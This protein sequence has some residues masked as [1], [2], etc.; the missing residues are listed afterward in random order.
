MI[1]MTKHNNMKNHS[2]GS[3]VIFISVFPMIAVSIGIIVYSVY[4]ALWQAVFIAACAMQALA[5]LMA[6]RVL[7]AHIYI[8]APLIALNILYYLSPAIHGG[9]I[10]TNALLLSMM[11]LFFTYYQMYGAN[12][13]ENRKF[14]QLTILIS[15]V[16]IILSTFGFNQKNFDY[17]AAYYASLL[18]LL[19]LMREKNN[20]ILIVS[21]V[22][23][24]VLISV[25]SNFR[26]MIVIEMFMVTAYFIIS[27]NKP[28][29]VVAILS[30]I[31]FLAVLLQAFYIYINIKRSPYLQSINQVMVDWTGRQITSGR[32][33]LW[34]GIVD[35]ISSQPIFGLGGN[36]RPEDFMHTSFSA[37]NYYLQ[38]T[39]QVGLIGLTL[40]II[41]LFVIWNR[42]NS[43]GWKDTRVTLGA[44]I[45]LSFLLH[46]FSEVLMFQNAQIVALNAWILIGITCGISLK[47][48]H[49]VPS[50]R[51]L[52]IDE[53]R[54]R[55]NST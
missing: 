7:Y 11:L 24:T 2:P 39:L 37:H 18:I 55:G 32:E 41:G 17:G 25:Y 29:P 8:I 20:F 46:N 16:T 30:F 12:L 26:M 14:R 44:S 4:P 50:I 49:K 47:L 34:P 21:H 33:V 43:S 27:Y 9:F 6:T 51:A 13:V 36:I 52:A 15:L 5:I 40:L 22:L 23:L 19:L 54:G 53:K 10:S 28:K 31:G 45:F 48:S 38:L 35:K 42:F 1:I 3:L